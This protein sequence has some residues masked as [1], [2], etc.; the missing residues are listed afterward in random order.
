M[1][2]GRAVDTECLH[3]NTSATPQFIGSLTEL[4][5]TQIENTAADLESFARHAKRNVVR[6][7]DVLL[8]ARRN[9]GLEGILRD[10]VARLEG[11]KRADGEEG[12]EE[13]VARGKK[14]KGK[15]RKKA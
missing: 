3:L 8:L 12:E 11:R 6:V 15:G 10:F 1:H 4:V 7:E 9:E 13:E 2:I 5:W 14:G